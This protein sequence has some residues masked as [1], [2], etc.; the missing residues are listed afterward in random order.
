VG[1]NVPIEIG[2][3]RVKPGD[4]IVAD[5]DGVVAIPQESLGTVLE[6]IKV[7]TEVEEGMEEAIQRN[8]PVEDLEAIIGRKKRKG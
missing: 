8:A 1:H 7:I 2:G 6:N 5:E 3:V 4:I